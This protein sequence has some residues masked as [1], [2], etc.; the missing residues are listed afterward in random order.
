LKKASSKEI[1]A[2]GVAKS[3]KRGGDYIDG[4]TSGGVDG[5]L[6]VKRG[7]IKEYPIRFR[8]ATNTPLG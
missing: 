8:S 5:V 7:G 3:E 1:R 2:L 6:G 4:N